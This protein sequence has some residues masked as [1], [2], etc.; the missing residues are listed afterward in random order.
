[1]TLIN[2]FENQILDFISSEMQ[3]DLAHDI[4]HVLRVVKTAKSL[5]LQEKAISEVAIPA[6][7]LHDCFSLAKN[8]PQ[9]NQ[10]A[11]FAAEKTVK[12]LTKIGYPAQY[13]AAIH[14]AIVAHSFS[15][16]VSPETLE[17]KIVQDADRL[18][19]LGAVGIARCLQV[20]SKLAR[21][22]YSAQDPFCDNRPPDD[23]RFSLDHFYTKLL[24]LADKMHTAAAKKEARKR[25]LFMQAYLKQLR[26]EI[27]P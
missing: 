2:Q 14:H 22:L 6:A 11:F 17:A 5:C 23:M 27:T 8:H 20:G 15:A 19:A 12:F 21:P 25:T 16:N 7:Y 24:S 9:K 18:D 13:H 1:M 10:S 4:S 3:Q 26:Q